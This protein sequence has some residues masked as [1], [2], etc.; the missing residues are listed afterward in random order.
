MPL[1]EQGTPKVATTQMFIN[2]ACMNKR[3]CIHTRG[4]SFSGKKNTV[5][6]HATPWMTL[7]NIML[8]KIS[9]A[10]KATICIILLV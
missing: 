4:I 3:R 10:Q 6:L 1:Q 7:K 8:N 9:Q 5:P 2:Y